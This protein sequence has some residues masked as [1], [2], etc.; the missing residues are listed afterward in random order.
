M[1][2]KHLEIKKLF[3]EFDY[4]IPFN[5]QEGITILTGPNGYGKTAI[6]NIVYSLFNQRFYFFK[7]LPFES[8]TV[9]FANEKSI[10]VSKKPAPKK[11]Q[12]RSS[13]E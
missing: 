1:E 11:N 5:A 2:L 4:T 8:I 6:L 7:K 10:R 13:Q 12:P 3:G 9:V